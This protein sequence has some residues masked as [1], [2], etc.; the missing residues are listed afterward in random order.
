MNVQLEDRVR[1]ALEHEPKLVNPEDVAVAAES[2]TVT[3]RGTVPSFK[4]RRAAVQAAGRVHG[5][6]QVVDELVVKLFHDDR[7]DDQLRGAALRALVADGRVPADHVDV[8]VE[9]AWVTLTGV[10]NHQSESNAAFEDVA[11][12]EDVGGITNKIVV[13]TAG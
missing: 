3:L 6:H 4:E 5:V 1:S 8:K 11:G 9:N 7:S 13:T 2:K 10:V 12:L